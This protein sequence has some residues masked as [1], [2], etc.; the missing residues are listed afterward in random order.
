MK[1]H[2]EGAVVVLLLAAQNDLDTISIIPPDITLSII[3]GP[4]FQ[5]PWQLLTQALINRGMTKQYYY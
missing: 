5:Y 3:A 4:G 1:P 2:W